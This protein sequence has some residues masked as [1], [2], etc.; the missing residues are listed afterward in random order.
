MTNLLEA[1][2][3]GARSNTETGPGQ[4]LIEL[5]LSA[6][7][8]HHAR[9]IAAEN[10]RLWGLDALAADVELVVAELL[11]NALRHA[12]PRAGDRRPKAA[13]CLVRRTPREVVV[14]VHDDDPTPP[15]ERDTGS[16]SIDGRGLVLV[17][18]LAAQVSVVTG[19]TGK[20]VVALLT[21]SGADAHPEQAG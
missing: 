16:D 2:P 6:K 1:A 12:E 10:I 7:S 20:E 8:V 14:T 13:R 11:T 19:P 9:A 3:P 5:E 15:Q 4:L 17:R 18:A 21:L